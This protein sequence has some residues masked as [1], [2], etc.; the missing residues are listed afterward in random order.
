MDEPTGRALTRTQDAGRVAR[1]RASPRDARRRAARALGLLCVWGL[2]A[3][4]E[5][6][7]ARPADAPGAKAD[8]SDAAASAKLPEQLTLDRI[9]VSVQG[10]EQVAA[11]PSAASTREL[12]VQALGSPLSPPP[13]PLAASD[14]EGPWTWALSMDLELTQRSPEVSGHAPLL[15]MAWRCELRHA[16]PGPEHE[17]LPQDAELLVRQLDEPERG[18]SLAQGVKTS[19][20]VEAL[21]QEGVQRCARSLRGQ[22][23]LGLAKDQEVAGLLAQG[24]E[25]AA[26]QL[27]LERARERQIKDAALAAR[28]YLEREEPSLV[29]AA[30]GAIVALGDAQAGPALVEAATRLSAAGN[31]RDL[32]AM[33]YLLGEQG[34]PQVL[35]YLEAVRSGHPEPEL[36]RS[37][38]QALTRAR[39]R[40]ASP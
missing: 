30:A 7:P 20:S 32:R 28:A 13:K 11:A 1:R 24:L 23:R 9:L 4:C 38:A 16:T 18:R 15:M 22:W 21:V 33:I 12:L 27:A 39:Q 10:A 2:S 3:A 34:G 35:A 26:A 36:Q 8:S 37:A 19:P 25:G 40:E 6:A 14:P 17:A 5:R 29:L 31:L